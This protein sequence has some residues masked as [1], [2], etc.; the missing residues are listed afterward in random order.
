MTSTE[1]IEDFLTGPADLKITDSSIDF[2]FFVNDLS[3]PKTRLTTNLKKFFAENSLISP[4]GDHRLFFTYFFLGSFLTTPYTGWLEYHNIQNMLIKIHAKDNVIKLIFPMTL[5]SNDITLCLRSVILSDEKPLEITKIKDYE[6]THSDLLEIMHHYKIGFDALT[7]I[8]FNWKIFK[9]FQSNQQDS[10]LEIFWAEI[11]DHKIPIKMLDTLK[12]FA[13]FRRQYPEGSFRLLPDRFHIIGHVSSTEMDVFLAPFKN[14]FLSDRSQIRESQIMS[15]NLVRNFHHIVHNKYG[16]QFFGRVANPEGAAGYMVG[17]VVM[18]MQNRFQILPQCMTGDLFSLILMPKVE[19]GQT[20]FHTPVILQVVDDHSSPF[21][22]AQLDNEGDNFLPSMLTKSRKAVVTIVNFQN[23]NFMTTSRTMA[24]NHLLLPRLA[25]YFQFFSDN[26][27]KER[28]ETFLEHELKNVF[29]QMETKDF[30]RISSYLLG[31]LCLPSGN[32][33]TKYVYQFDGEHLRENIRSFIIKVDGHHLAINLVNDHTKVQFF[34]ENPKRMYMTPKFLFTL[35]NMIHVDVILAHGQVQVDI[36]DYPIEKA[37]F[38]YGQTFEIQ[39]MNPVDF[40][41]MRESTT[42]RTL[43]SLLN[44]LES[45]KA[46][47][48]GILSKDYITLPDEYSLD[49]RAVSLLSIDDDSSTIIPAMIKKQA[50]NMD[51][52]FSSSDPQ[53]ISVKIISGRGLPLPKSIYDVNF[54]SGQT[55]VNLNQDFYERTLSSSNQ[56]CLGKNRI[57]RRG[58]YKQNLAH[59]S[60]PLTW[61]EMDELANDEKFD[62]FIKKYQ[63]EPEKAKNI[64]RFLS[65]NQIN[66]AKF[67]FGSYAGQLL[68]FLHE[69]RLLQKLTTAGKISSLATLGVMY[70]NIASDLYRG[71]YKGAILAL[72]LVAG[73]HLMERGLNFLQEKKG[74]FRFPLANSFFKNSRPF[75]RRFASGFNIYFLFQSIS[76]YSKTKDKSALVGVVESSTFFLIDAA[77]ISLE[78]AGLE[79]ALAIVGPIGAVVGA[80][81]FVGAEVYMVHEKLDRVDKILHLTMGEKFFEGIFTFFTGDVENL[82]KDYA[83]EKEINNRLMENGQNFLENQTQYANY[84]FPIYSSSHGVLNLDDQNVIL[85]D[86]QTRVIWP[87]TKPDGDLLCFTSEKSERQIHKKDETFFHEMSQGLHDFWLIL[88]KPFRSRPYGRLSF[89]CNNAMGLKMVGSRRNGTLIDLKNGEDFVRA[90][91]SG[92]HTY[93]IGDG[94]KSVIGSGDG[95]FFVFLGDKTFGHFQGAGGENVADFSNYARNYTEKLNLNAQDNL[96]TVQNGLFL[97]NITKIN[98]RTAKPDDFFSSCTVEYYDGMG[99]SDDGKFM[100]TIHVPSELCSYN[101]DLIIRSHTVVYNHAYYGR[102]RY[103]FRINQGN[104]SIRV[105]STTSSENQFLFTEYE[106]H[107][108]QYIMFKNQKSIL[109]A[110]ASMNIELY[111]INEKCTI[112][113]KNGYNMIISG[114]RLIQVYQK[115]ND[116]IPNL[117][118]QLFPL[119]IRLGVNFNIRKFDTEESILI[120]SRHDH[121]KK[122]LSHNHQI[123]TILHNDPF[124]ISHLVACSTNDVFNIQY[125]KNATNFPKVYLYFPLKKIH[126]ATINLMLQKENFEINIKTV[127]DQHLIMEIRNKSTE[128]TSLIIKNI[129]VRKIYKRITVVSTNP[130]RISY[131]KIL[132][133]NE[134]PCLVPRKIILHPNDTPYLLMDKNHI[135]P[136]LEIKVAYSID[137]YYLLSNENDVI[138]FMYNTSLNSTNLII[139][140]DFYDIRDPDQVDISMKFEN[141]YFKMTWN[142]TRPRALKN[143]Q[144]MI[145][146]LEISS[147]K[148]LNDLVNRYFRSPEV[149]KMENVVG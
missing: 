81:V 92:D 55:T 49:N 125:P 60:C 126:H 59:E 102:F 30:D 123:S 135:E 51:H 69:K 118:D 16:A 35:T 33:V 52:H 18:N 117:I 89:V 72:S 134:T 34:L 148:K 80:V 66:L 82:V 99:G 124:R 25:K 128:I 45:K 76:Q 17:S 53:S 136:N 20:T 78:L 131:D 2:N 133:K 1:L 38:Y 22:L 46:F 130:M 110:F 85:L 3:S 86:K 129:T 84:I 50:S 141:E 122:I 121:A 58:Y 29:Y 137:G 87:N 142:N 94:D 147:E 98:G 27:D 5:S 23:P 7:K 40:F 19:I 13:N 74:I 112:Y 107:E 24:I 108:L 103:I 114:G 140:K 70:K 120:S 65:E 119:S 113:F 97:W 26:L 42:F 67:V 115:S 149:L 41:Q 109:F 73:S 62:T 71:D 100:D 54:E 90:S 146:E 116:S 57:K 145:H 91:T 36:P 79:T 21:A 106:I 12:I 104:A 47:L 63:N 95:D 61:E 31:Q 11:L 75:L 28:F 83:S 77:E 56:V 10:N 9:T 6:F 138:L 48:K 93:L 64:F 88:S 96:L 43:D 105:D 37:T 39:T 111:N 101:L 132:C 15:E 144:E 68:D 143:L 44:N 32:D 139:F 127:D 4:T 8:K 14:L